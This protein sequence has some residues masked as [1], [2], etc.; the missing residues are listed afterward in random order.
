VIETPRTTQSSERCIRLAH[1][2]PSANGPSRA[3]DALHHDGDDDEGHLRDR[4]AAGQRR[5]DLVD[6]ADLRDERGASRDGLYED[7]D[8]A[9]PIAAEAAADAERRIEEIEAGIPRLR[10]AEII[11]GN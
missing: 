5:L 8:D 9:C 3:G 4:T 11:A 2:R 10:L 1:A 6:P 7:S